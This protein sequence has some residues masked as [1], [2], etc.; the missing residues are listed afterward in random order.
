MRT[1]KNLIAASA[2]V[3]SLIACGSAMAGEWDVWV[4]KSR[5]NE[6]TIA[7]SFSGDTKT[8]DTQLDLT[9]AAGFTVV[10]VQTL[11]AGSVCAAFPEKGFVRAVPPSG[12]GRALA[13]AASDTCIFTLKLTE[14]AASSR[15]AKDMIDV[16][17]IECVSSYTGDQPCT[18]NI[19][20]LES[21]ARK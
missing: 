10:D 8:E 7:A 14:K 6:I 9:V 16:K 17:F 15:V 2:F 12:A 18:S 11:V 5:N 4:D 21:S 19:R 1:I 3:G 20:A 13:K